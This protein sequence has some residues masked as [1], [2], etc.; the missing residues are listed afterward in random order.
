MLFRSILSSYH[1]H[2]PPS[3]AFNR[4]SDIIKAMKNKFNVREYVKEKYSVE[5][6]EWYEEDFG[7][8][9]LDRLWSMGSEE[10]VDELLEMYLE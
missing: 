5:V 1:Y 6:L 4:N 9:G 7:L 8:N 10:D 3:S 2:F